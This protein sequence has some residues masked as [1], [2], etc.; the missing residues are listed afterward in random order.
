MEKQYRQKI[1]D[2]I[3]I[4]SKYNEAKF[5]LEEELKEIVLEAIDVYYEINRKIG[6]DEYSL[7]YNSHCLKNATW[8]FY[9]DSLSINWQEY[10][11][12]D[13][14]TQYGSMELSYDFIFDYEKRLQIIE[15]WIKEYDEKLTENKRQRKEHIRK[16][17]EELNKKLENE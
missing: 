10:G 5:S 7:P 13:G 8:Y 6:R 12:W 3:D 1:K 9:D 4:R 2:F 14:D 11:V 16:Q 17:I 15:E